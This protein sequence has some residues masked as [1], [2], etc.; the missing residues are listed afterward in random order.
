MYFESR[1]VLSC[2]NYNNNLKK[3]TFSIPLQTPFPP[4]LREET[5]SDYR[6]RLPNA[7]LVILLVWARTLDRQ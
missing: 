4:S 2:L 7:N 5:A 6:D 3:K 1:V